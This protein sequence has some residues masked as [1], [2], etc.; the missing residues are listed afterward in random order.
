M[1]EKIIDFVQGHNI[2]YCTYY[3][4]MSMAISVLKLFVKPDDK[5]ILFVSYGGRHFNDSPKCIYDYMQKDARFSGYK[6]VWAF[7]DPSK[8]SEV[9]NRIKIDTIKYF[10]T[11]LK[12]RCWVTNVHI[13]RGL[14]FKGKHT[15]YFNT[16]HTN[17][18]KLSGSS[19]RKGSTF[20]LK[21]KSKVDYLCVQSEFEK[22]IFGKDAK[23][24][25]IV[26]FPKN[27]AFANYDSSFRDALRKKMNIPDGKKVILYAPTYRDEPLRDRPIPVDFRKWEEILGD[28]YM[29]FFRGH[30]A[31]ACSVKIDS[32][33]GFVFDQSSYPENTEL[34][35][36][37]DILIS[38][39]SGIFTEFGLQDKPMYCYAYDYEEYNNTRG[40]YFDVREVLPGGYMGEEELL[41]YIKEGNQE[42]VMNMVKSF[43]EKYMTVY[44][45]ATE[46]CVDVIFKNI[47]HIHQ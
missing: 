47:H 8:F 14:N 26:G 3:Y 9:E 39:Y 40:L 29:V 13:E 34:M 20:V 33:T 41:H 16:S 46:T 2:I 1:K 30:P 25:G 12:A 36:A 37:C 42:E 31:V 7:R 17:I 32:S 5:L 45:H 38:D 44:G 15:Y 10:I 22:E 28:Q 27:D 6:L 23:E 24:V 18:P 19:A 4:I 21:A 35:I 43:R 11:A